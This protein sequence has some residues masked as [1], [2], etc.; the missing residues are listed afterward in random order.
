[1]DT[2]NIQPGFPL[3]T[4]CNVRMIGR[5]GR[6]RVSTRTTYKG[7][8]TPHPTSKLGVYTWQSRHFGVSTRPPGFYFAH[9]GGAPCG[10]SAAGET[11]RRAPCDAFGGGLNA[12]CRWR[13]V[14][15]HLHGLFINNFADK[16]ARDRAR[17]FAD[18]Y[19]CKCRSV[20]ITSINL[21][22]SIISTRENYLHVSFVSMETRRLIATAENETRLPALRISMVQRVNS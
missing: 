11:T 10:R 16:A 13:A 15:T 4:R 7:H 14:N 22:N 17:L 20:V 9:G 12:I 19:D 18:Y 21:I 3:A 5:A 2:V 6:G 1:M 8:G